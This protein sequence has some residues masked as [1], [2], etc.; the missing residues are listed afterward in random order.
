MT[1]SYAVS[2]SGP[3]TCFWVGSFSSD[4]CF[5]V[6]FSTLSTLTLPLAFEIFSSCRLLY[7]DSI[8]DLDHKFVYDWS[9]GMWSWSRRLSGLETY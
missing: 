5:L 7:F 8:F 6:L 2:Q 1:K 4:E 3:T 9:A